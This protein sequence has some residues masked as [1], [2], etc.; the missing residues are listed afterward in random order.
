MGCISSKAGSKSQ[1]Q[2]EC[3]YDIPLRHGP[4]IDTPFVDLNPTGR[5]TSC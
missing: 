4:S 5:L 1:I 3:P 2:G